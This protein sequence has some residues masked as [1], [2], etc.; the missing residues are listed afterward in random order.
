MSTAKYDSKSYNH[1][2]PTIGFVSIQDIPWGGSEELWSQAAERLASQ[3]ERVTVNIDEVM[4]DSPRIVTLKNEGVPLALRKNYGRLQRILGNWLIRWGT[5][6]LD[7][8]RPDLLVISQTWSG[9]GLEWMEAC[10]Q[11]GIP[12]AVIVQLVGEPYPCTDEINFRLGAS[13]QKASA[14]FVLSHN[15]LRILEENFALSLNNAR[16]VCNP[17]NVRYEA[18]PPW[19]A[20]DG[21]YRLA[22][23][24]RLS[25]LAKGQDLLFRV[26]ALPKWRERPLRVT[27]FGD[28]PNKELLKRLKQFHA[29]DNV[30][31]GGS[32]SDI[33]GVWKQY[34][35][36]VLP[37][38]FEG[39]PLVVV[40]AMLCGRPCIVTDVAGNADIVEDN[41]SGFVAAAPTVPLLDEAMERAWTRRDEWE[42]IGQK[43]A[44][45][46]RA[47][48]PPDP[49]GDFVDGLHSLLP[50]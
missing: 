28:G 40:E 37:S 21:C 48:V 11:R 13:L 17:F 38:R 12:Y 6:W 15:N 39:L 32:T 31:F 16:V 50:R 23:I 2:K 30:E 18:A 42:Q 1:D 35:A 24:G 10:Q 44:S 29:L 34:D 8:A 36:L 45:H 33:E 4:S 49:I 7:I 14:L 25:P 47:M 27:L 22:C 46:I 43:A 41:I 3:G 5:R 9:G 26:L 20:A 19:P